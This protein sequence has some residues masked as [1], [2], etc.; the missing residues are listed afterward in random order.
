MEA[1]LAVQVVA[2]EVAG[3]T[4][5][6]SGSLALV[7]YGLAAIGPG[8]GIAVADNYFGAAVS[9]A[10]GLEFNFNVIP[11]DLVLEWRP[12]LAI[13][14]GVHFHPVGFTGHIRIYLF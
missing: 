5:D 14:P 2:Q 11:I 4:G 9:G 12:P 13:V 7:G 10:L 3:L 6:I 1:L 8:V